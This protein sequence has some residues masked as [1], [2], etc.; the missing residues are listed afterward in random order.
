MFVYSVLPVVAS[1]AVWFTQ[2]TASYQPTCSNSTLSDF[3][4]HALYTDPALNVGLPADGFPITSTFASV[5]YLTWYSVLTVC[6]FLCSG[7]P[8]L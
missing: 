5:D 1:L 8:T 7:R 3:K 6:V 2:A 4:I